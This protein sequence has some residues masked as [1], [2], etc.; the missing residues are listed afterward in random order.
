VIAPSMPPVVSIITP[1]FNNADFIGA[2]LRS[3]QA[4]TLGEWECIVIDDGSTDASAGVVTEIAASD[5]RIRLLRQTNSGPSVARNRGIEETT[6]RYVLF[7]DGDDRI[8]EEML[9]RCS[10][11]L[12]A[13]PEV[14]AAYADQV[15]C[16][17]EFNEQAP[18]PGL[19]KS[20]KLF[21][22][23]AGGN[24]FAPGCVVWRR[25]LFEKV[26]RFDPEIPGCE[27]W[28]FFVQ[29]ARL[30]TH[31]ERVPIDGLLY[32]RR[33]GSLSSRGRAMWNNGLRTLDRGFA[34][35][36]RVKTPD[37]EF[38]DGCSKDA[39]SP[40]RRSYAMTCVSIAIAGRDLTTAVELFESEL[41]EGFDSQPARLALALRRVMFSA[42]GAPRDTWDKF[43]EVSGSTLL[44]W[45]SHVEKSLDQRGLAGRIIEFCLQTD[46]H[47]KVLASRSYR[48]SRLLTKLRIGRGS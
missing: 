48:L 4:Q 29:L 11:V 33:C 18:L 45:L 26:G 36:R 32:T 40:A 6:G 27:D 16:F 2:T 25:S 37:P 21:T 20:G 14:G 23:L 46:Q 9:R 39:Y 28:D 38:R 30:G 34:P 47:K 35:D 43:W 1:C 41:R 15:S 24:R 12:D 5:S 31:F 10:D 17:V 42:I 19:T 7:L 44:E 13:R 3:V 22:E 8:T